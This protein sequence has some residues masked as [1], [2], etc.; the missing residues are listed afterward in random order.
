M[1]ITLYTTHCPMCQVIEKKLKLA[2][3]EYNVCENVNEIKKLGYLSA[4][5]LKVDDEIYTFKDANIWLNKL[6]EERDNAN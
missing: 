2:N 3:A 5:L 6:K 1:K 4:P